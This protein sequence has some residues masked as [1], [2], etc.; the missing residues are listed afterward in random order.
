[1]RRLRCS[2][3]G[4]FH[5]SLAE[6]QRVARAFN[7]LGVRV[8]SPSSFSPRKELDGFLVLRGDTG[9]AKDM[10]RK[11]LQ[12]IRDSD[13]LYVVNPNG[14]TGVSAVLEIGFAI[15]HD[16]P[17][18]CSHTPTEYVIK[19]F[20]RTEPNV[21]RVK[22]AVQERSLPPIPPGVSLDE[23]QAYLRKMVRVRGFENESIQDVLLLM[24]EEFGELAKS[25]RH[26]VGLKVHASKGGY[27]PKVAAEL[28]DCLIYLLDIANLL[29]IQISKAISTKE[30]TNKKRVWIRSR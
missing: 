12:A 21:A 15:A 25:L 13:F 29:D 3:S 11:H 9:D 6:I 16:I 5:K 17:V 23:L 4:S 20:T 27:R 8:L 24:V 1:M 22:S 19:L 30:A 18:F 14:E 10:Q 2:I 26:K 28:A 7:R